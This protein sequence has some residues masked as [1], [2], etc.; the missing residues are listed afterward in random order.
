MPSVAIL[1]GGRARRFDGRD[2]SALVVGG[3]TI[4]ERQ[5]AELA[6]LSDDIM[7]VGGREPSGGDAGRTRVALARA[8][9]DRTPG[10]G[11]L[12]G[13]DAALAAARHAVVVLVACDMPF[14][15][16]ALC[17]RLTDLTA[18]ADAVVPRTER[19][20]HPLCA[21][22]TARCR[23]AVERRLAARQLKLVDLLHD[24]LVRP[25]D[26]A[27]LAS[28][29]GDRLLVNVNTAADYDEVVAATVG[30]EL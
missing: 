5:L 2:K 30:H 20:Y 28:L 9:P 10:C 14:V 11:P 21:A 16:A 24:L 1:A 8:V 18:T 29:G 7:I 22:Y 25:I 6:A 17:R 23:P 12:S 19:G 13:L 4:L 3:R 15:T 27:E 26:G